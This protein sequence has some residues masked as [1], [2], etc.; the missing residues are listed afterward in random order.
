[1]VMLL[2]VVLIKINNDNKWTDCVSS[3]FQYSVQTT[4]LQLITQTHKVWQ[5]LSVTLQWWDWSLGD[6]S[7]PKQRRFRGWQTG[8]QKT[9]WL[10]TPKDQRADNWFQEKRSP[11]LFQVNTTGWQK[12]ALP[13]FRAVFIQ[14]SSSHWPLPSGITHMIKTEQSNSNVAILLIY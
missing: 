12:Q 2:L 13:Y 8:V 3:S 4:V 6:V 11:E 10:W 14:N 1:M 9:T 7:L 5:S